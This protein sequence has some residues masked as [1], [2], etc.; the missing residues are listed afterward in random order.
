M[1][2]KKQLFTT[3]P[4]PRAEPPA[5]LGAWSPCLLMTDHISPRTPAPRRHKSY[6]QAS[7][8]RSGAKTN[9]F[10]Y[11]MRYERKWKNNRSNLIASESKWPLI[12]RIF[13]E[14]ERSWDCL[15]NSSKP[16]SLPSRTIQHKLRASLRTTGLPIS[17]SS[18]S[19]FRS[20]LW[21]P[22]RWCTRRKNYNCKILLIE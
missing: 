13:S 12:A 20:G 21:R 3:P 16:K 17:L 10:R 22:S 1:A 4:R 11:S 5:P 8:R 19:W 7:S 9:S 6:S 2:S 15:N 14:S 18:T